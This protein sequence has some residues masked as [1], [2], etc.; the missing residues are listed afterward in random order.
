MNTSVHYHTGLPVCELGKTGRP[1]TRGKARTS[2]TTQGAG[3]SRGRKRQKKRK[4][5]SASESDSD[6]E[7]LMEV[8]TT[9]VGHKTSE[10]NIS[11]VICTNT[12]SKDVNVLLLCIMCTQ[13]CQLN[14]WKCRN[15]WTEKW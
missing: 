1:I 4:H 5:W 11:S 14:S 8:Q 12:M 3:G 9:N 6:C 7:P 2:G 13:S 15:L 10:R